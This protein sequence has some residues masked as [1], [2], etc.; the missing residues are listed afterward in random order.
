MNKRQKNTLI[1]KNRLGIIRISLMLILIVPLPFSCDFGNSYSESRYKLED[2]GLN[3][4]SSDGMEV[5]ALNGVVEAESDD[6]IFSLFIEA[7]NAVTSASQHSF[8]WS[9]LYADPIVITPSITTPIDLIDIKTKANIIV[10]GVE[11]QSGESI[12]ELF[13]AFDYLDESQSISE[14]LSE[15]P[16]WYLHTQINLTLRD[17][18]TDT[19]KTTLDISV[20]MSDGAIFETQ[21]PALNLY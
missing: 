4:L 1:S 15:N 3:I 20:I 16:I 18:L 14:Y 9:N 5:S 2:I 7:S 21:T 13:H 11:Y 10:N 8:I 12:G 17:Q 19:L 6:L